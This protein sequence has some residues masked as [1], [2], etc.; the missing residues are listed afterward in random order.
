MVYEASEDSFL[1]SE[2]LKKY[3]K[4]K[5][6][7]IKILDMGAGSG[8]QAETCK[9]LGFKNILTADI[10]KE[11]IKLLKEKGF[12]AVCSDLFSSVNKKSKF[13]LII[14]NPPYLPEDKYDKEKDTTGGKKG[15]ETI[16][17][18]LKQAK[19]HLEKNGEILLLFSSLSKPEIIIKKAKDLGYKITKLSS[20]K[21]FFEELYVYESS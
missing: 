1:L 10:D 4:Y 12:K 11:S 21:L 15:C 19:K 14:F 9:Q 5:D 7:D 3:L 16:V 2:E 17:K 8:I 20:K 18:F 13:D 6:R